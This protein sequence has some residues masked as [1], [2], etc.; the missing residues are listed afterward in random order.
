MFCE[1]SIFVFYFFSVTYGSRRRG[2]VKWAAATT[3]GWVVGPCSV[4]TGAGWEPAPIGLEAPTTPT[5]TCPNGIPCFP[6][7]ML[8]L[9]A[10]RSGCSDYARFLQLVYR[11]LEI[12]WILEPL[13]RNSLEIQGKTA[14]IFW[15]PFLACIFVWRRGAS[16]KKEGNFLHV[17]YVFRYGDYGDWSGYGYGASGYYPYG[18]GGYYDQGEPTGNPFDD[19][20]QQGYGMLQSFFLVGTTVLIWYHGMSL[21][22]SI[23]LDLFI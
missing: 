1:W 12:C 20:W 13:M 21:L 19:F 4:L 14:P 2:V 3:D 22:F 5:T 11:G 7:K 23:A 9:Y 8:V 17:L 6:Q 16:R 10:V 15:L 18:A